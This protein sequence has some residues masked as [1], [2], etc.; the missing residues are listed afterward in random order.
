MLDSTPVDASAGAWLRAARALD[1]YDPQLRR[2]R[3]ALVATFTIDPLKPYLKV[4]AARR[5]FW[6]DT[7]I[8]PFDSVTRELIDPSS[9]CLRHAPEVVFVAQ[10]LG[11]VCPPLAND[12]P[13]L[14]PGDVDRHVADL[15]S[16][17]RSSLEAFRSRSQ[18]ALVLHNF[19]VP[20]AAPL[21][22]FE[23]M[24]PTSQLDAVRRVN[25]GLVG[26]ARDLP[27]S[28]ILDV[29]RLAA[30]VGH[31]RWY[32]RR[33][34][35]LGRV[36]LSTEGFRALAG[37][38]ATFLHAIL[39][40]PRKCLVVD[41]DNTLWHGEVGELG[42]GGI[43]IGHDYPGN[44]FRDF[45]RDLLELHRR[46]VLLAVSSKNNWADVEPVFRSHPDMVLRLEHFS[47][48]RVNWRSK[49]ESV[50]DIAK[51]LDIGTE[52]LVFLDDNPVERAFMRQALPEV[53]TLELPTDF[54]QF[55]PTL[56]A[57]RAFDRLSYTDED[58]R[59]GSMYRAQET[60]R[61]FAAT[62]ASVDE[63]LASLEMEVTIGAVDGISLP[64]VAEL[65]QKTNQFNVTTRRHN[66]AEIAHMA[67]DP[68]HGVF[69]VR[70]A[71]RF[72]D[73]GV[74]GLA[75]V[76]LAGS[77]A[78]LDTLLLSC[79]VI[80]RAV[81]TALLAFL[82]DWV[83]RRGVRTL[84]AEFIPTARNT[85]ASDVFARHGFER[86]AETPAGSRWALPVGDASI[87][88]PTFMA[89]RVPVES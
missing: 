5:Q 23:Q 54:V 45:Q 73:S 4:E 52:S 14:E 37:L 66:A 10:L 16:R 88:Y 42:I 7:Y 81:E 25:E 38:Q 32:D 29:D 71:D 22:I 63:F 9:G 62:A 15:L 41:L 43:G 3:V 65:A 60:R 85:P 28:Y 2:V 58:R 67:D 77:V 61:A 75:I 86:I 18:A 44:V 1:T 17:L 31:S 83:K 21:G 74:V 47:A 35:Y 55:G 13:G 49:P 57:S 19:V 79:R 50:A 26:I 12:F 8:A 70:V 33:L 56:R 46:G 64:R 59:R 72:G 51:D 82:T 40:P 34:W 36:P 6:T 11:D 76:E 68:R 27:N 24:A 69:S 48:L 53:L 20:A 30:D 84:E 78:R 80:G 39:A 89:C 87:H